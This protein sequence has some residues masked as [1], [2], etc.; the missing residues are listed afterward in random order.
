MVATFLPQNYEVPKSSGGTFFKLDPGNNTVR[1]LS[2]VKTGWSYWNKEK[3]NIRSATEFAKLP[4][5]IK[6][7]DKGKPEKPRHFWACLVW[8]YKD[9]S[10]KLW[11]ITQSTIQNPILNLYQK[12]VWGDPRQ[13]DLEITYNK[14]A[15]SASQMYAV[16]AMPKVELTAEQESA[17]VKF[18]EENYTIDSWFEDVIN[19]RSPLKKNGGGTGGSET[20]ND[21]NYLSMS[22]ADILKNEN[23]KTVENVI[24]WVVKVT[25]L[26]PNAVTQQLENLKAQNIDPT[27]GDYFKDPNTGR[28]RGLAIPMI[29][30]AKSQM[31][32]STQESGGDDIPF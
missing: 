14:D 2:F 18:E 4:A 28:P 24:D 9:S 32:N 17:F 27:T 29:E 20:K 26:S 22:A 11:E 1:I 30:W 13:Y 6:L 7:D 15:S 5:D 21:T 19:G 12:P 23:L 31:N 16:V 25:Q 3:K 10:V 8:D